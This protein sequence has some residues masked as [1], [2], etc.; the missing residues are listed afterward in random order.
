MPR[1]DFGAALFVV[2]DSRCRSLRLLYRKAHASNVARRGVRLAAADL[3]LDGLWSGPCVDLPGLIDRP[4]P[5][6]GTN[7]DLRRVLGTGGR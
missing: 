7:G 6:T 4:D 3:F 2:V 1:R 5:G